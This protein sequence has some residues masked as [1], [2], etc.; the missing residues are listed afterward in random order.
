[1]ALYLAKD[2]VFHEFFDEIEAI[3]LQK[4]IKFSLGGVYIL[5]LK[6]TTSSP[7]HDPQDETRNILI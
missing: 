3:V 1:V 5:R 4:L 2:R 7:I 6:A